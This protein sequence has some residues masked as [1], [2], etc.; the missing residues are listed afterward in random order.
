MVN[1][2]NGKLVK[3]SFKC[4]EEMLNG[5]TLFSVMRC[6]FKDQKVQ[7]CWL[8]PFQIFNTLFYII[9]V[10]YFVIKIQRFPH[11]LSVAVFGT[12]LVLFTMSKVVF[13]YN[14]YSFYN[15]FD[16]ITVT[17]SLPVQ[18][19]PDGWWLSCK[20]TDISKNTYLWFLGDSKGTQYF[21]GHFMQWS[22]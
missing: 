12:V 20:L 14:K 19:T 10:N 22:K 15:P 5:E 6:K 16:A 11:C 17:A 8:G 7:S 4:Q 2:N 9:Y 13:V 3:L 1:I 18:T 21:E